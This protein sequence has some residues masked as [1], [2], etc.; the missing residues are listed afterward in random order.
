MNGRRYRR[1]TSD[2]AV[3][4]PRR[5]PVTEA[6]TDTERFRD[7]L[8]KGLQRAIEERG[9]RDTTIADIVRH[10]RASRRTFYRVFATKDDCLLALMEAANVTLIQRI[11]D[12]V[13]PVAPWPVQARQAVSAYINHVASSP[14]LSL[15]WIRELPSLGP[16]A[17]RV[18]RNSMNALADL[19]QRLTD[20]EP[21]RRDGRQPVSRELALVILGGLRELTATVLEAGGDVR[22][23]LE[24]AVAAT[25]AVLGASPPIEDAEADTN[26]RPVLTDAQWA[27][28]APLLPPAKGGLGRPPAPHRQV[29]EAIVYRD[30]TGI[31]WRDLPAE[32]GPWQTAWKRHRRWSDDGTWDRV[33][34]ELA[35]PADE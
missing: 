32:F 23:V 22:D 28:V 33:L 26:R 14:A 21:F 20:N 16:V 30:R 19:V 13:D 24:V 6:G 29:V 5:T 9:Y 17:E 25:V 4:P 31:A 3:S 2:I 10:A 12:A 8:L 34:T 1:R 11:T 27:R 18:K 15:C 35:A 7:R